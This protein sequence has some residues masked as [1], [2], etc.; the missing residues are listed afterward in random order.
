MTYHIGEICKLAGREDK[1][2]VIDFLEGSEGFNLYEP[3]ITV[4]IVYSQFE[5]ERM[6][7][8]FVA[9]IGTLSHGKVKAKF[10]TGAE[11]G[12]ESVAMLLN[13]GFNSADIETLYPGWDNKNLF[14]Q[15]KTREIKTIKVEVDPLPVG[16]VYN[17]WYGV[18]CRQ[19]EEGRILNPYEKE[20]YLAMKSYFEPENFTSLEIRELMGD[21]REIKISIEF[22]I[23]ELLVESEKYN[24]AEV[25]RY[26]ELG[27]IFANENYE[28]LKTE[29]QNAGTTIKKLI[30]HNY[31]LLNS[32][33]KG[34]CGYRPIEL[35]ISGRQSIYLDWKGFLHVF[36]RHV[37][38][39]QV[40][41]NFLDKSKFLWTPDNVITVIKNVIESIDEE[42]QAYWVA[43]P[44]K[45]VSRFGEKTVHFEGD[46]YTIQIEG[47]GRLSTF[48]PS[49]KRI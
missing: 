11:L 33:I 22:K 6:E 21:S 30:Q 17:L 42:I 38:E 39:F 41:S 2:A 13:I 32:L 36:L 31:K 12:D 7:R 46:Y 44:G 27:L 4:A 48:H 34:C 10:L 5:R 26:Q 1:V 45:R 18:S 47:N 28:I 23:L 37:I 8:D 25:D 19:L 49:E 9:G 35:N 43:N 29:I 14:Y 3:S 16:W 20:W 40:G 15:A 24:K